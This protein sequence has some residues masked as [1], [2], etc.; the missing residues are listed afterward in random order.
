MYLALRHA[1]IY[2]RKYYL[3]TWFAVI[4][5]SLVIAGGISHENPPKK[6]CFSGILKQMMTV[7]GKVISELTT[8]TI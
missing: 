8:A 7:I 3:T 2:Q 1:A 6:N 4:L 5:T